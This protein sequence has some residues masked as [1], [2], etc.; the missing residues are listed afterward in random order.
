MGI[1]PADF[2]FFFLIFLQEVFELV[3]FPCMN[4]EYLENVV[5]KDEL[6][7]SEDNW[8]KLVEDA[9]THLTSPSMSKKKTVM[10]RKSPN[11]LYLIGE[12]SCR[13]ETFDLETAPASLFLAWLRRQEAL[14]LLTKN[15]T[16]Y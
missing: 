13:I 10:K 15:F 8:E 14:S 11:V 12:L 4:K 9:I 6:V 5:L 7:L 2:N 3:R 1:L 16:L